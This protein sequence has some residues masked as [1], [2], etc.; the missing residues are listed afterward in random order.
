MQSSDPCS[1]HYAALRFV[2]GTVSAG[3]PKGAVGDRFRRPKGAREDQ[4][5]ALCVPGRPKVRTLRKKCALCANLRTLRKMAQTEQS[6]QFCV[7]LIIFWFT[8]NPTGEITAPALLS[9]EDTLTAVPPKLTFYG[10]SSRNEQFTAVPPKLTFYGRSSR[11]EQFTAVP[12]RNLLR[13]LLP[14]LH[15]RPSRGGRSPRP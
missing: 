1:P 15:L 11:N 12:P 13:L 5:C 9:R 14:E 3:R 8:A 2:W 4:K 7:G 10:S 6:A